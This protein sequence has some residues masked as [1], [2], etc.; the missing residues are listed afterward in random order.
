[1]AAAAVPVIEEEEEEEGGK[2]LSDNLWYKLSA[3]K[4]FPVYAEAICNILTYL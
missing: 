1:V 2:R 4:K 3:E